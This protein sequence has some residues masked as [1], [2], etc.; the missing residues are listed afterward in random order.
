MNNNEFPYRAYA[1]EYGTFLGIAW[2]TV[3]LLYAIGFRTNSPMYFL[4][5][6]FG[7]ISLAFMPFIFAWRVR[8]LQNK[9]EGLGFFRACIF[10]LNLFMFACLFSGACEYAYFAFFDNGALLDGFSK[11]VITE[12]MKNTY[13]Q[14]GMIESYNQIKETLNMAQRLTPFEK[15]EAMFNSNILISLLLLLPVSA[16]ASLKRKA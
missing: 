8:S 14:M 3:F 5:A 1:M 4:L 12:E 13:K 2:T 16:I 6:F 11:M 7:F 15:T 9:N 10:T